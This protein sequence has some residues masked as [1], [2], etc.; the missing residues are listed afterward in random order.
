MPSASSP[1]PRALIEL[2]LDTLSSCLRAEPTIP[3]DPDN[4]D[5][6][7]LAAFREDAAAQLPKKHC[8]FKGCG[9]AGDSEAG[10]LA[11]IAQCHASDV[12]RVA[13]ALPH[14]FSL[15]ERRASAYSEAIAVK[16][17]QGAPFAAHSIDRRCL[18]NYAMACR[19]DQVEAPICFFCACVYPRLA[20][21]RRDDI[22][23]L[24]PF[25][26]AQ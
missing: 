5:L 6:P 3:A 13:E 20:S 18:Y 25:D 7:W 10:Q 17:R 22:R 4:L 9:W 1:H 16:I 21:R 15:E 26:W 19:D 2:E 23:W 12:D 8:A 14:C 11:H 24:R